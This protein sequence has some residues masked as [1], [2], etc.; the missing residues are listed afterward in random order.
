MYAEL[1][2]PTMRTNTVIFRM[3]FKEC[4]EPPK[5]PGIRSPSN[6]R[7]HSKKFN[8]FSRLL[9]DKD[10]LEG[11][12]SAGE[13]THPCNER[14]DEEVK[15]SILKAFFAVAALVII[16]GVKGEIVATFICVNHTSTKVSNI[17]KVFCSS[18]DSYMND[19]NKIVCNLNEQKVKMHRITNDILQNKTKGSKTHRYIFYGVRDLILFNGRVTKFFVRSAAGC[20]LIHTTLFLYRSEPQLFLVIVPK[21]LSFFFPYT[22]LSPLPPFPSF[23][24]YPLLFSPRFHSTQDQDIYKI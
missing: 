7:I 15:L 2:T 5:L 23:P 12:V 20:S 3:D 17:A 11:L 19:N 21:A 16:L 13:E 18:V 22:L 4:L 6:T 10:E 14:P 9:G 24:Q 8:I 1:K